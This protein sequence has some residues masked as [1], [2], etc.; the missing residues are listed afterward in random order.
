V[1][2]LGLDR[3]VEVKARWTG[4]AQ[5][6]KWLDGNYALVVKCDRGEPVVVMRLRDCPRSRQGCWGK[7][8][9]EAPLVPG[10]VIGCF[11]IANGRLSE[12]AVAP[13]YR[14]SPQTPTYN[15]VLIYTSRLNF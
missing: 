15:N 12:V 7:K 6:S 4:F 1:P 3:K 2:L 5:I 13:T 14:P 11:E 9:P 10:L 8:M